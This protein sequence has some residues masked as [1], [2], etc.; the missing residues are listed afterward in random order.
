M[1]VFYCSHFF[2]F[3]W[4][5]YRIQ[6]LL[7]FFFHK[8]IL[9]LWC[10]HNAQSTKNELIKFVLK[11]GNTHHGVIIMMYVV[12]VSQIEKGSQRNMNELVTINARHTCTISQKN[13]QRTQRKN[14]L[15]LTWL[16]AIFIRFDMNHCTLNVL[17]IFRR[18]CI[19]KN[20]NIMR[21]CVLYHLNSIFINMNF[22]IFF[23]VKTVVTVV[24]KT[25][26]ID[27]KSKFR[28]FVKT[29]FI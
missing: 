21:V 2:L 12:S 19:L 24:L 10:Q 25:S 3:G 22:M 27:K 8:K 13:L 9:Y 14:C 16:L 6:Y 23:A 20:R 15:M 26:N 29:C 7:T 4:F 18:N 11:H 17:E 28:P 1:L 5:E